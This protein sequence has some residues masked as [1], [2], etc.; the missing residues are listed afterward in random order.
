MDKGCSVIDLTDSPPPIDR[1]RKRS[2]LSIDNKKST[3]WVTSSF[4][5][6]FEDNSSF[7]KTNKQKQ[8]RQDSTKS[9]WS[10]KPSSDDLGSCPAKQDTTNS[11]WSRKP[12]SDD[13]GSSR[14]NVNSSINSYFSS[15]KGSSIK[16]S[17]SKKR[18]TVETELWS[19]KHAPKSQAD[20]AVHKKKIGEVEFWIQKHLIEQ[21]KLPPILLL[22]GPSGVGKTAT[23][24]ALSHDLQFQIQEWINPLTT[25]SDQSFTDQFSED[26]S[27]KYVSSESQMSLF[28]QF[29][30]R[31]NK[32]N[33]LG[34]FGD[35]VSSRRI[36]LVEEFPN[37]FYRD[38]ST[39]HD[40]IRKYMKIGKCPLVFIVSDSTK[41]ES[42]E[43]LL[44]PKDLQ[45]ELNIE[46]ICFNAVAPTSMMKVLTKIA[47]V[48]SSQGA[49]R[50]TLP[51]KSVIESIAM[52]SAGDIRGAINA[53]QFACEKDTGDLMSGGRIKGKTALK[54]QSNS[55]SSKLK[56]KPTKSCE[57]QTEN[58]S[59]LA[60][61][62]GRDTSLFLFRAL[63]K[64]LYCKRD[65]PS[66]YSDL[67][68][69]PPHLSE[70]ER[71]PLI[72][73]PEDVIEKSHLSGEYFTAYLHQNYIEFYTDISDLVRST[74]YLSDSDYLTVEWA[75]RS[76][77]QEYAASVATRGI[78][79]CN[80]SRSKYDSS[81]S[82]LGWR[83][84]NKPQ[85][86]TVNKTA[87]QNAETS[88]LLFKSTCHGCPPVV[89]QTEILPYL[90]LINI[91]LNNPGQISFLQEICRYS[92]MKLSIRSEKLDEKDIELDTDDLDG[93][94]QGF[95]HN[96]ENKA[97]VV[98]ETDDIIS[99]SQSKI[100]PSQEEDEEYE[101]EEFDY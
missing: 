82:G 6:F 83:P 20:L 90:S 71:D 81:S 93:A 46:N 18:P 53:L 98:I 22:T 69:L 41:G 38:A 25:S 87:R 74:E 47:T 54:K 88:R 5:D 37:V 66:N 40:I 26:R 36:I 16:I 28:Q 100:D 64:I 42:N 24:Q 67:P 65:D 4:D 7:S 49:H 56:P 19:D 30:L 12:S 62:G 45:Q 48:E 50:F 3:P 77:L 59:E 44:F 34:I 95:P 84:L 68:R 86:Y 8:T 10:R 63:G 57:N 85:W 43:R 39:F 51:S 27:F 32:Y 92:K 73:N 9:S 35:N 17:S 101:I 14:A 61:I 76:A 78:I 97:S 89:L 91:T 79:H 72:I 52:S 1:K 75:S 96:A 70:H 13:L 11:S 29:L 2:G 60:S 58:D 94:S 31:A 99:N 15:S 21:N 33:T 80:S 55:R 23:V